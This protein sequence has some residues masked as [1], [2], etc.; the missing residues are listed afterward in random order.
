MKEGP[1]VYFS[2]DGGA[3]YGGI[4]PKFPGGILSWV[5]G[6]S[7]CGPGWCSSTGIFLWLNWGDCDGGVS[8]CGPGGCSS[9]GIFLWLNWGD[10]D[11]GVS[12]CG[13]GGC[14]S[15]G[16]FLWLNWGDCGDANL[17]PWRTSVKD[18]SFSAW[19]CE[20]IVQQFRHLA[21]N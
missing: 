3:E 4:D 18:I 8:D 17:N 10:C 15:T 12:G 11:G 14:S 9:T 13:P 20:N 21:E 5:N 2:F 16:I 19:L 1:S 7:D 6:V